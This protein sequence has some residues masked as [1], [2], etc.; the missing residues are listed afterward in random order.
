MVDV[1][2]HGWRMAD[3][4]ALPVD[5]FLDRVTMLGMC[6]ISS[7]AGADA[8][9]RADTAATPLA[10]SLARR[11]AS[12]LGVDVADLPRARREALS[13][14]YL[15]RLWRDAGI[16]GALVDDGY[17]LP[18]VDG[19]ELSRDSGL[20]VHRVAR[21]EPMISELRERVSSFSELEEAFVARVRAAADAVAFKSVIAY[22]TGLDVREWS[23]SE[24]RGA[25]ERWRSDGFAE[26]REHAKPVRDALLRRTLE[27]AERPVH[28]HCGG[29]DP[30]V[31]LGRARP[32]DLFPTLKAFGDRPIVLIHAGWP[33]TE[34]AAYV[35]SILPNV[36]LDISVMA[37][38]ASLAIDAK[39]EVLLGAAPTSRVLYGSD[40]A[41]EPEVLWFTAHVVR[42]ALERVLTR[43][44]ERDWTTADEARRIGEAVLAGNTRRLHGIG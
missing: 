34:E 38:W 29:G 9:L 42:A 8:S 28:I 12:H 16:E 18:A 24:L 39:L 21:I 13:L 7:G 30:D 14:H 33:W 25:F 27:V 15:S 26:T 40:E 17:P 2:C 19:A 35:A 11:L 43:A 22:R 20:P 23:P 41:S 4:L 6:Q 44:T 3:L 5:G 37:P 31:V 32:Q 10:T 1:H 36:F